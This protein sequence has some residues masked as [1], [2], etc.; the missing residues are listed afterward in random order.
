[1]SQTAMDP[2]AG[3]EPDLEHP[4][5]ELWTINLVTQSPTFAIC[6]FFVLTRVLQ[7][8]RMPTWPLSVD[9][10]T[11]PPLLA[12]IIMLTSHRSYMNFMDSHGGLLYLWHLS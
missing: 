10:C 11:L 7:R 4:E 9:E 2:P 5:N 8:F 3:V 6:S 1:M 12:R